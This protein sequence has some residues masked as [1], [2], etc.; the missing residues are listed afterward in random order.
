M[1]GDP[2]KIQVAKAQEYF[3]RGQKHAGFHWSD[4]LS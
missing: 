4:R 3:M 1:N 2:K